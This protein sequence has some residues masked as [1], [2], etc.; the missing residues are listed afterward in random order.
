M[1]PWTTIACLLLFIH[2]ATSNVF[3]RT[4]HVAADG[5]GDAPSIAA[6]IDS[7][8]AGDVISVGPGTHY[9]SKFDHGVSMKASTR[10]V[11]EQGPALTFL[12]PGSAFPPGQATMLGAASGCV[13]SGFDIEGGAVQ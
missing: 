6:A 8:V 2:G 7:S 12:R 10:L 9:V 11:S 1:R 5:S 4:W 3:A 13:V